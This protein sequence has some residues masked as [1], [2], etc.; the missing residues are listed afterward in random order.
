MCESH[1][2][3]NLCG[4]IKITTTVQCAHITE[5]FLQWALSN[6]QK[7]LGGEMVEP[8]A[9]EEKPEHACTE[10]VYDTHVFPD[11]CDECKKSG[12]V[13][14]WMVKERGGKL[15]V[16]RSWR[17]K[18]RAANQAA[19][20]EAQHWNDINKDN[21]TEIYG[22]DP[23]NLEYIGPS[24]VSNGSTTTSNVRSPISS[25]QSIASSVTSASTAPSL[26]DL[27]ARVN[28][29]ITRTDH[30]IAKIRVQRAARAFQHSSG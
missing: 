16:F 24:S 8:A 3:H 14:D 11:L 22:E 6:Q 7:M 25:P 5:L 13:G 10:V 17:S 26:H 29:L 15:Q 30:L 27:R 23:E 1:A 18:R 19:P 20:Q 2:V 28:R 21:A 12:V 4:H 9:P